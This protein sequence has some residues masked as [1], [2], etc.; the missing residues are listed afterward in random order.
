MNVFWSCNTSVA[1]SAD[2]SVRSRQRLVFLIMR[3]RK[4]EKYPQNNLVNVENKITVRY[5]DLKLG[6]RLKVWGAYGMC[7]V[8]T[9]LEELRL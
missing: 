7:L 8:W 2:I 1:V 4:W 6:E 5:M 9:G 3:K